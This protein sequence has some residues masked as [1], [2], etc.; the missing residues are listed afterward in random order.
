[1]HGAPQLEVRLHRRLSRREHRRTTRNNQNLAYTVQRRHAD[2]RS[3]RACVAFTAEG[4]RPLRRVLRAGSVDARPDDAAGRAALRSRV[5]LFPDA[6]DRPAST[7]FLPTPLT[8]PETDGVNY[9]DISPRGGAPTTSSAT[10]RRRSRSTS[11]GTWI[12][13]SNNNNYSITNPIARIATTA[14]RTW[15]DAGTGD[16]TRRLHPAVQPART[17]AANGECLACASQ[18]VRDSGRYDRGHRSER[19]STAGA[20]VRTTGRSAR[21]SSSR[22][23]ARVGRGRLLPALARQLHGDRQPARGGRRTSRRSRITAPSDPRLPGGGG[24]AV[25]GLYNVA[26]A[27]SARPATTSRTPRTTAAQY[28]ALQRH[29]GQRQRPAEQ[30]PDVPGRHQ[31]RQDRAGH[32][33]HPRRAARGI[34][35]R[36]SAWRPV[37]GPTQPVLPQRARASSRR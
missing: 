21:R 5:E 35:P 8:F 30:R 9:K 17:T 23:A 15:I 18:H 22:S 28:P 27:S 24:Y 4:S 33:R 6:D 13:P 29:A 3:P 11:A 19:C 36:A 12:R 7:T 14:T 25:G 31:H 20:S 32:L 2:A 10:A 1:M 16:R 37:V 34:G 26:S